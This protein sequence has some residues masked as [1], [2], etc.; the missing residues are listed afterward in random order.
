M[1]LTS[2]LD[3]KNSQKFMKIGISNQPL[4]PRPIWGRGIDWECQNWSQINISMSYSHFKGPE[5]AFFDFLT[6]IW[7]FFHF[8][9]CLQTATKYSGQIKSGE[10]ESAVKV[11]ML[12]M[13]RSKTVLWKALNEHF[14]QFKKI[15]GFF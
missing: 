9:G 7:L 1:E 14:F 3:S 10:F 15:F 8:L 12:L 11:G 4:C 2:H 13:Y 5:R 6:I